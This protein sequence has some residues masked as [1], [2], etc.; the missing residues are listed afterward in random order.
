MTALSSLILISPALHDTAMAGPNNMPMIRMFKPQVTLRIDTRRL[1]TK[2]A[3]TPPRNE[4]VKDGPQP[5]L[6]TRPAL[7]VGQTSSTPSLPRSRPY[8]EFEE[9]GNGGNSNDL[10]H[11][12]ALEELL[13]MQGFVTQ[14]GTDFATENVRLMG[15]MIVSAMFD[16]LKAFQVVDRLVDHFQTGTLPIGSGEAGKLLYTYWREAPNRMSEMERRTFY[17]ATIGVSGGE[18]KVFVNREFNDLWLRF[19]SSVS[20]F[21]RQS[22]VDKLLRT[23]LPSSVSHQQVRKAARDLA[24]NL[25]LHGYGMAYYATLELQDQISFMIKLLGDPEIRSAYGAPDIWQVIDQVATLE[26]GGAKTSSRY[27]TLATC[28]TIITAWLANNAHRIMS[29]TGPLIDID[30]VGASPGTSAFKP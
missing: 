6:P 12:T 29:A 8:S 21:V 1:V 10:H 13:A 7:S 22:E 3:K 14:V 19:V 26:L 16:E 24:S 27:R 23:S 2:A 18:N 15:P 20:D 25:S 17:A 4:I 28:G 5:E 11:V 9:D 30:E